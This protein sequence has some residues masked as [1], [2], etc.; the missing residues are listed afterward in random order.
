M[1]VLLDE[2]VPRQLANLF[3]NPFEVYTVQKMG[4]TGTEN[5][6]LIK[7]AADHQFDAL[8]TVDRGFEFQQDVRKLPFPVIILFA[9][10]NRYND[11]KPLVPGVISVLKSNPKRGIYHVRG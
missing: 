4:W 6:H 3:T 1:K 10:T 11:L 8:I 5:G 9:S 7:I 2:S